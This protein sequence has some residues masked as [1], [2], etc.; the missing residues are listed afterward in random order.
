M[1][2]MGREQVSPCPTGS[3]G[4]SPVP[5]SHRTQRADF[6]HCA[7]QKL[8]HSTASA[9]SFGYRPEKSAP[10]A[11]G[12]ARQRFWRYDWVLDL[13]IKGFFDA[14]DHELLMRAVRKH[15]DCKWMLL[16]IERWL[17]APVRMADGTESSREKGTPQGGVMS[18]SNTFAV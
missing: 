15:T 11:V 17:K 4:R 6:L 7:L 8:I 14:I 9:C 1:A 13:D 10:E 2:G 18:L 5:G 3:P 12:V 16:Y